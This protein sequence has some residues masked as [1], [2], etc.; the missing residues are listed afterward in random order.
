M[1]YSYDNLED[2]LLLNLL[3]HEL[4]HIYFGYRTSD[5][6]CNLINFNIENNSLLN[7]IFNSIEDTRIESYLDRKEFIKLNGIFLL[8]L[9]LSMKGREID[10]S[11][12]LLLLKLLSGYMPEIKYLNLGEKSSSFRDIAQAYTKI[13]Q[14]S[15]EMLARLGVYI[16]NLIKNVSNISELNRNLIIELIVSIPDALGEGG[17]GEGNSTGP[18]NESDRNIGEGSSGK[19]KDRESRARHGISSKSPARSSAP[20]KSQGSGVGGQGSSPG[21]K[22]PSSGDGGNGKAG[23]NAGAEPE[24]GVDQS[25]LER[26]IDQLIETLIDLMSGDFFGVHIVPSGEGNSYSPGMNL[27][28][29]QKTD[30]DFMLR[31]MS[32]YN[33]RRDVEKLLR[34]LKMRGSVSAPEGDFDPA[35]APFIYNSIFT[36]F[37]PLYTRSGRVY[38]DIDF[39]ILI[40]QS[41][42]T[43]EY[44]TK[45]AEFVARFLILIDA[46][47]RHAPF[48]LSTGVIGFGGG[49]SIYKTFKTPIEMVTLQ[50]VADG[51]TP[52][53]FALDM[54]GSFKF[55]RLTAVL[56]VSDGIFPPNEYNWSIKQKYKFPL[57]LITTNINHSEFFD[58][59]IFLKSWSDVYDAVLAF[60]GD[61]LKG[62]K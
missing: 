4:Y 9:F 29:P 54:L 41:G 21:Q 28:L 35:N 1:G 51:G 10:Y 40:D 37:P 49:I 33:P 44:K 5:Y 26:S 59:S 46:F 24:N 22:K 25:S 47:N 3:R 19:N 45:I 14:S 62:L 55:S 34:I 27:T 42:S 57:I 61:V 31:V 15:P 7:G 12:P 17:S 8:N 53:Y 13:K 2:F 52:L 18:S 30:R 48:K 43:S 36:G 11:N 50:P 56:V 58:T 23:K 20:E 60:L 32:T 16:Y 39:L 6:Y 38:P